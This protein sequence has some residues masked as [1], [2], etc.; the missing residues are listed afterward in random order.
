MKKRSLLVLMIIMAFMLAACSSGSGPVKQEGPAL[1]DGKLILEGITVDFGQNTNTG[2]SPARLSEVKATATEEEN[3][4][5]SPLYELTLE[6]DFTQPITISIP[7][8]GE[9]TGEEGETLLMGLGVE[10]QYDSG[11]IGTEYFYF[12]VEI[13]DGMARAS[14]SAK[15]MAQ[16]PFYMG[17]TEG[18][19]QP[20]NIERGLSLRC[21]LFTQVLYFE[22]GGHFKLF[23]PLKVDGKFFHHIIT[24]SGQKEILNDLEAVYNKYKMLGYEYRDSDFPMNVLIKS[25]GDAGSYH[26]LFKDIT[27]NTNNFTKE[28]KNGDLNPLLWH[29]FFHYVQGC[30][31]GIFGDT[32]WIDEATASFYE[33][34]ALGATSTNLTAEYFEKQFTSALPLKDTPQDGYA[35]SPLIAY[36][37]KKAGDDRWIQKV[38][39]KGGT[40]EAFI[41]VAGDPAGW[42]HDYYLDLVTGTVGNLNVYTLHRSLIG[43]DY[44][45]D[46]GSTLNIKLPDADA[47]NDVKDD[48]KD[49]LI[50]SAK[51]TMNGQGARLI[52][53]KADK[54]ELKKLPDASDIK[55]ECKG[56][57]VTV[58]SARGRE[59]TNL[60]QSLTGLKKSPENNTVYLIL[61]TSSAAPETSSEFEVKVKMARKKV[62]FSGTY[63]GIM[64]SVKTGKDYEVTTEVVFEHEFG[65]GDYYKITTSNN[66]SDSKYINGSYFVRKNGEVNYPGGKFNFAPDGM[67]LTITMLETNGDVRANVSGQK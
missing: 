41:E 9:Y 20:S 39:A 67:S 57:Q 65:D 35:R 29:E 46:V 16:A 19:A 62:D 64:N 7:L 2:K 8:P 12:P 1:Q 37:T 53:L 3:G 47:N 14:F 45:A 15:E 59:V 28:Y 23:H 10:A 66:A 21:G 58:L 30:Y 49:I 25:I 52:A 17:A 48:A 51:V 27:L 6:E 63:H 60:G 55:V 24:S 11:R 33:A 42:A 31:T 34:S 26:T 61:L 43:G 18:A 54:D 5:S 40:K 44:G 22:D 36:L 13:V 56:A 4:L 32:E 38:Y 50:G